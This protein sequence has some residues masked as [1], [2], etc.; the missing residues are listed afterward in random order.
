MVICFDLDGTLTDPKEGIIGS[1]RYALRQ[2]GY[3]GPTNDRELEW[4]I[5]PPLLA[6]F[7]KLVGNPYDASLALDN[8]RERFSEVG[9]YE[10][11][12]YPDIAEVLA[13]LSADGHR[14]FV[15]TSKPTVYAERIINHFQLTDYFETVFGSE[16]DGT[17]SDKTELLAWVLSKKQLTAEN[18]VMVGD[19][20]HD[21][22]GA[23]NNGMRSVGVLYGYGSKEELADAGAMKFYEH[24]I[25]LKGIS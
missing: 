17:R 14:M 11:E 3:E 9:L 19:R 21:I 22:I 7:E 12:I 23:A 24:P 2:L 13:K 15:A 16:L 1:I 4:C 5:G 20:S 8:Y 10:N 18:T 25:Q 6:S